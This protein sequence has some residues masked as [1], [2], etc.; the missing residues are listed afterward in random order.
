MSRV[1]TTRPS[2]AVGVAE[3]RQQQQLLIRNA[4]EHISGPSGPHAAESVALVTLSADTLSSR[5]PANTNNSVVIHQAAKLI[6]D[7][8]CFAK[9]LQSSE[10]R[11][12]A[13][14]CIALM[15]RKP[16]LVAKLVAAGVIPVLVALLRLRESALSAIETLWTINAVVL[17]ARASRSNRDALLDA[18]A[19]AELL[20]LA[21]SN[22][23]ADLRDLLFFALACLMR[24]R[25]AAEMADAV[26]QLG[27][28]LMDSTSP[29]EILRACLN[30]F[31]DVLADAGVASN[32]SNFNQWVESALNAAPRLPQRL[33]ELAGDRENPEVSEAALRL[34]VNCFVSDTNQLQQLVDCD[35]LDEL[36][37]ML[38]RPDVTELTR[39]YAM[40][41]CAN[42]AGTESHALTLID[43]D[44]IVHFMLALL[45]TAEGELLC[46][47]VGFFNNVMRHGNRHIMRRLVQCEAL[48]PLVAVLRR[49]INGNHDKPTTQSFIHSVSNMLT[50]GEAEA[51]DDERGVNPYIEPLDWLGVFELVDPL[52]N[53]E[54]PNVADLAIRAYS[55]FIPNDC[56]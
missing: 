36:S 21:R 20:S 23:P 16:T 40:F 53:S 4:H 38:V 27:A 39:Q 29:P 2:D 50:V 9:K 41:L 8:L 35:L 10:I 42:A 31:V 5:D 12:T 6:P 55:Y 7:V 47:A 17:I 15:V 52:Q 48:K 24:V 34:M 22:I 54:N 37:L 1:Q 25:P 33:V 18:G 44:L 45:S 32:P 3:Q 13:L 19:L 26:T 46:Y 11:T 28:M 49:A 43:N 30:T 14:E 51:E 56:E